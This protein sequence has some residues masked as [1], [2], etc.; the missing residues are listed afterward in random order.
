MKSWTVHLV[1]L[2]RDSSY[3]I[4]V[5]RKISEGVWDK[6]AVPLEDGY[7]SRAEVAS[8]FRVTLQTIS[9]RVRSGDLQELPSPTGGRIAVSD[10]LKSVAAG[11]ALD[12]RV[13]SNCRSYL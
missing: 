1:E 11:T 9:N 12:R 2:S 3:P 6:R 10:V 5:A 7:L 8:L 4:T 13:A